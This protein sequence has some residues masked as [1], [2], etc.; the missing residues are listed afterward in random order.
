MD[1]QSVRDEFPILKRKINNI[2]LVY[3]DNSA[4]SQKPR[5]VIDALR[6]FYFKSNANIHRGIHTLSEE[7]TIQYEQTRERVAEFIGAAN[8]KEVIFTSNTTSGIN[9]VA[10]GLHLLM[11]RNTNT[12]V[13]SEMEHHSNLVPWQQYTRAHNLQLKYVPV[14]DDFTLDI[15]AL[16]SI[17]SKEKVG[18]VSLAHISNVLGTV[19]PVEEMTRLAKEKGAIVLIDGAQSAPHFPVDVEE[20]GCDFFAFSGHKMCGPTGVG[21]L[22]GKQDVLEALP[23]F[24]FGGGMIH[25]VSYS[26]SSWAGI[27]E[28]FEAGTPNF[29]DVI[30]FKEAIDFLDSVGMQNIW[31]HE[32][33]L[34]AYFLEN[35]SKYSFVHHIGPSAELKAGVISIKI[36]GV[37]PHD[38]AQFLDNKGIAVRAGHHCAQ[39]L[40]KKFDIGASLRAS[41]YLYNTKEEI[42]Y[43]LKQLPEVYEM[44]RKS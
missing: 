38:A 4:T 30:A 26:E 9:L 17:L 33:D 11:P 40:H 43:F 18:F 27:P 42:D 15:E 7:A 21:V 13:I 32:Q 10:Q 41:L 16:K 37:H 20:I 34:T 24:Q 35:L 12:I 31:E 36:D 1:I 22:Y 14:K 28:R 8:E 5:V 25:E 19:N 23:P 3:F 29:A 6:D 39:P 44:F 2:P